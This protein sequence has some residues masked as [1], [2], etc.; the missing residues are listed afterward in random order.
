M[1][2]VSN[3]NIRY[4]YNVLNSN[5]VWYLNNENFFQS[6]QAITLMS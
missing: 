1:Y 3:F 5:E 2:F 6:P 4:R